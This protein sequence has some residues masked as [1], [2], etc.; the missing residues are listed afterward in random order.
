MLPDP[1]VA[2]RRSS[3]LAALRQAE[4]AAAIH[5]LRPAGPHNDVAGDSEPDP[6]SVAKAIVLRQLALGPRTRAQLDSTLR[7]R[8]CDPEVA[9]R[10]LDRMTEVGLIDDAAF[11]EQLVQSRQRTKGLSGAAL[12]KELRDKGVDDELAVAAVGA[13]DDESERARAEQLAV[14][15]LRSLGGLPPQVQ[16][17]RLAGMLARKGYSPGVAYA[18]VRDTLESAPEHQRD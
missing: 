9:A 16:A 1:S 18:V 3:A 13:L 17:R 14:K 10:V 5:G 6:Q 12:R 7:R 8:G 4:A 2:A 15:R 11:A